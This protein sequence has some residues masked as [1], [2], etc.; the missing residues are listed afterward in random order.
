MTNTDAQIDELK[1]L[2]NTST[3]VDLAK[4]LEVSASTIQTWRMRNKIPEKIFIKA[5]TI[6]QSDSLIAPKGYLELPFYDVEVSAGNG[7]LVEREDKTDEIIFSN[8]FITDSLGVNP[9]NIF[10]MPV[11][12][13]SMTPTLK[14]QSIIMVNRVEQLVEDGI[15]VFRYDGQLRVKRL[16]FSKHGIS[17]VSDNSAYKTWELEKSELANEDFEIIGEVIWSGQRV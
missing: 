13:D 11:K 17:V 6:S 1:E 9:K 10:L 12:G 4:V 14:S 2:T 7:A 15:Y 3:N 8:R 16:Q 5:R